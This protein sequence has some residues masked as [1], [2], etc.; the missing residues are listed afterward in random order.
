MS[1]MPSTSVGPAPLAPARRLLPHPLQPHLPA[2]RTVQ[3]D[4]WQE[5][6]QLR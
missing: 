3:D 4:R 1:N 6:G 2:G 5:A